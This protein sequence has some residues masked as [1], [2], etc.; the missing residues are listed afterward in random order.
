[1]SR[2][3]YKYQISAGVFGDYSFRDLLC[4]AAM[5]FVMLNSSS[6]MLGSVS[7]ITGKERT[8]SGLWVA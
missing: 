1:M 8:R 5:H 2:P 7:V 3:E 4:N 6:A